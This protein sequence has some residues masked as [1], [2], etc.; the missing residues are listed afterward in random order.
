MPPLRAATAEFRALGSLA[1]PIV[2]TQLSQMGMGVADTLMVARVGATDLAGVTLG[3]NLYFPAML[4][5]SGT[6]MALTPSVSQLHGAGR[7]G[8]AGALV[9]QGLW[10]ALCG[11]LLLVIL[12]RNVEPLYRLLGV[13]ERA[14]PVATAYLKAVSPSLVPLLAYACLRCLCEGLSWTLPAMLVGL[15]ALAL[16]V[17]LNWLFIHGSAT[18][19]V[20]AMGGVGCGWATV[21]TMCYALCAML[22]VV[23]NSRVRASNVFSAFSLPIWREIRRLLRLGLPIGVAIFAEVAFFSFVTLLIGRLGVEAVAAHQVAFNIIGVGFM[24]PLAL[25]M[26]ATIRVGFNIGAGRAATARVAGWVAV[27][28]T[29][30]WGATVALALVACRHQLAGLY[31]NDAAVLQTAGS[32][33]LIAAFFQVFDSGQV[34]AMG[35]LRGHKDTAVPMAFALVGYWALGLPVGY[36]LCFGWGKIGVAGIGVEGLWWG[37]VLGLATVA[38]ALFARLTAVSRRR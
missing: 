27:G 4:L 2:A 16:K 37:L 18:L 17:A 29:L 24:V 38:V 36:A 34:A 23:L 30:A 22:V 32:L 19:G 1:L 21:L 6:L 28:A 35:V 13:D 12:L 20:P 33:L 9:R 8:E 25:G 31:T 5:L 26:A 3:N 7:T 15:S 10:I 11:S 14:I